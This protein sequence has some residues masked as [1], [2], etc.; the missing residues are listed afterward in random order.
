MLTSIENI[1]ARHYRLFKAL[2]EEY[3][4]V[5]QELYGTNVPERFWIE[6]IKIADERNG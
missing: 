2:K 5:F 4:K 6:L 3:K 1:Q